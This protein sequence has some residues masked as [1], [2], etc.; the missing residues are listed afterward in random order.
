MDFLNDLCV[1]LP[2]KTYELVSPRTGKK[3]RRVRTSGDG[4]DC[5][6]FRTKAHKILVELSWNSI[7]D[8]DLSV[9]EP[10]RTQLSRFRRETNTGKLT[11]D[12][13]G[14]LCDRILKRGRETA[15]YYRNQSIV[16]RGRY[17]ARVRHFNNCGKGPTKWI[18][19][20][21]ANGRVIKT[22]RG[23]S[24]GNNDVLIGELGFNY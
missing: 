24:N 7:D 4:K 19:R 17:V 3:K 14:E 16:R 22:K 6:A 15:R 1:K 21:S 5:V 10:G 20:V 8:L 12:V 23:M 13:A 2:I 11:G 9:T 18:L